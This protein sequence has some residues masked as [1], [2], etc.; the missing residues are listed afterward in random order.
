MDIFIG[1]LGPGL[2]VWLGPEGI[3]HNLNFEDLSSL[4]NLSLYSKSID[5]TLFGVDGVFPSLDTVDLE[6]GKYEW[7]I[8]LV[9]GSGRPV[10]PLT[11]TN[12]ILY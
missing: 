9:D 11:W 2:S 7:G 10:G 12:M 8:T 1:V 6:Q 4:A 5:G 3:W